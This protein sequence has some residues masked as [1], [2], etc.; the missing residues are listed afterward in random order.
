MTVRARSQRLA[1]A[2]ATTLALLA[3]SA[4]SSDT[5]D[6]GSPG[7]AVTL[8]F[9]YFT[10]EN[11][12]IGQTWKAWM[13]E[14]TERSN[15][16]ITF[17]EYWDG[18]LLPADG[19]IEGLN[20]GRADIAQVTPTFYSGKFPLTA[21]N[22][23]PF[24]TNNMGAISAAMSSLIQDDADLAAEWAAQGIK[25]LAWNV[26]GPS[27]IASTKAVRTAADFDGLKIRGIDRGSRALKEAGADLVAIA[28]AE[29]YGSMDRGVLDASYGIQLGAITSLKLEEVSD[30]MIDA[31][32]GAQTASTLAM[33]VKGWNAL[34][35]EQQ[36]II[37]EVSATVP[38][39][40]VEK[41]RA[42]EDAACAAITE[43]GVEIITLPPTEVEALRQAGEQPVVAGWM[44]E[45][46]EA[47]HDPAAF[48]AAYDA[49]VAEAAADF[50][51]GD[52]SGL[53]RCVGDG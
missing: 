4:C 35:A 22:E 27:A 29:L 17:E 8:R 37:E 39:L 5:P 23:L 26:G 42:A 36:R 53:A 13:A 34:T 7:D 14:V 2:A 20:D 31:S 18:T 50:P 43:A 51:D 33:S 10:S 52:L 49:A 32:T 41:N 38:Q 24:G 46:T 12:P 30:Y 3:A 21:V 48:R 15:G 16:S 1:A 19:V 11:N 45:V 25:P 40:Y 47:G 28:P 44:A 9:S 6:D